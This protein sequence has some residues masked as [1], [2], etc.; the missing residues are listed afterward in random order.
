[1]VAK[2][3]YVSQQ[4]TVFVFRHANIRTTDIRQA[5][6]TGS[7]FYGVM[8]IMTSNAAFVCVTLL[9]VYNLNARN[10]LTHQNF[11]HQLIRREKCCSVTQ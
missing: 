10:S 3:V 4:C 1:M 9:D 2:F 8:L 11:V 5:N 6:D 7:S